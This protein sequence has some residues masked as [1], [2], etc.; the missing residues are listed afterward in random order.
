MSGDGEFTVEAEN[1]SFSYPSGQKILHAI[2]LR[3]P[4]GSLNILM[5]PS[6]SG[7]TTLLKIMG[8]FLE[9]AQGNVF[10]SG[11]KIAPEMP[12]SLRS[13]IGYIPQQ[14]GL[15]RNLSV[16]ENTLMGC[17]SR[18]RGFPVLLG[19]FPKQEKEAALALLRRLG[20]EQKADEKADRLSGGERQ[21]VAIARSLMQKPEFVL[22]DEFISDLD[23]K[24]A[25]EILS[26]IRD[27]QKTEKVAFLISMHDFE[28]A[29]KIADRILFLKRG[30]LIT[31]PQGTE[32]TQAVYEGMML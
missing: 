32:L 16:L 26:L 11:E 24:T 1:I 29:K 15:V 2:S 17:L 8:G 31:C 28:L 9:P 4:R 30:E 25:A 19:I 27:I 3:V 6:G 12:L 22:A 5:G 10:F 13:R 14:L 23:F 21:R 7:K 20:L 18:C